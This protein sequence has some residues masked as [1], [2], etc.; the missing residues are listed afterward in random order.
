MIA[1]L[2]FQ[3]NSVTA[4]LIKYIVDVKCQLH[5]FLLKKCFIQQKQE[6]VG[7]VYVKI[8]VPLLQFRCIFWESNSIQHSMLANP[9]NKKHLLTTITKNFFQ[10]LCYQCGYLSSVN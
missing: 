2:V 4:V 6:K 7:D 9:E 1:F 8:Y 3:N 10:H 5:Q